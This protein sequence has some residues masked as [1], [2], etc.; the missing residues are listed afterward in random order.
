MRLTKHVHALLNPAGGQTITNLIQIV[1]VSQPFGFDEPTLAG[2]LLDAR[3]CNKRDDVTGALVCRRD[4]YLQLLE[5]PEGAVRAAYA[6]IRRD[7]WHAEIKELV[8]HKIQ[9]RLF[10]S[11][12]MLHD[13]AKTWI[14]TE[15]GIS[16]GALDRAEPAV[17]IKVFKDLSDRSEKPSAH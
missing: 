14:W 7:D 5:G 1:Y 12:A 8:S 9:S 16:D 2:I 17:I 11:W 13:P 10:A 15:E 3:R 6:R 4:I